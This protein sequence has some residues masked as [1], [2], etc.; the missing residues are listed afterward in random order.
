[1]LMAM[2][3]WSALTISQQVTGN[4]VVFSLKKFLENPAAL[5]F[6]LSLPAFLSLLTITV[7]NFVSD[8]IWTRYGRRKP[9]VLVGFA[10]MAVCLFLM[11]LM[12]NFWSLVGVYLL[13]GLFMDIDSPIEPLKQEIVPPQ[14][15]GTATGIMFWINQAAQLTFMFFVFGRFDDVTFMAG[16]P[17]TGEMGIYWCAALLS[18]SMLM[19]IALGIKE[20]KQRSRFTGEG[21][22]LKTFIGGLTDRELLPVYI[23]IFGAAVLHASTG[24]MGALLYTDQW[25]YTKQDM[26]TN[27]AIGG[28]LNLFLIALLTLLADRLNRLRAYQVLILIAIGLN[29]F[30]YCYVHFILPDRRP[31]LFEMVLFGEMMSVTG[32]LTGLVYTPLIYD[33]VVRN[34][35]GTY[36]AGAQL[37][38][39]LTNLVTVN[40]AGLFIVGYAALFQPPA[41]DMTRVA[42]RHPTTADEIR[43][44]LLKS[45]ELRTPEGKPVEAAD[46]HVAV[47]NRDGMVDKI[48][49][50][51]EIRV[52]SPRS[53]ELEAARK[54]VLDRLSPLTERTQTLNDRIELARREND[55]ATA[56]RLS[57]ELAKIAPERDR[58]RAE[59]ESIESAISERTAA[60]THS[61]ER[62]LAPLL[63]P[64]GSPLEPFVEL[65]VVVHSAPLPEG[66]A[67]REL[68]KLLDRAR[69]VF[70]ALIDVVPSSDG[71]SLEL[72]F[73]GDIPEGAPEAD[74]VR[75]FLNKQGSRLFPGGSAGV[76]ER[77]TSGF[78]VRVPTVEH[79]IPL[80]ESPVTAAVKHVR[81]LFGAAI[82]E[83]ERVMAAGRSLRSR[84]DWP[85]VGARADAGA[86]RSVSIVFVPATPT[87]PP[88]RE[89][90]TARIAK[91]LEA[92]KLTL[93]SPVL[94]SSYAKIKYDYMAGSLLT[95]LLGFVGFGITMVFYHLNKK[96]VIRKWGVEEAQATT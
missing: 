22:S 73:R 91:A 50:G 4:A 80:R 2:L 3:P 20:T 68:E 18:L 72:S 35:M 74:D 16:V 52:E 86:E 83:D 6:V 36:V 38:T 92:Q 67:N 34:K 42:L 51:M 70:P 26:G 29:I 66:T 1:M 46:L 19:L 49:K 5:T 40:G 84:P 90:M 62:I 37:V 14:Q 30:Y 11:P 64:A 75:A 89:E 24:P 55:T 27:I 88:D 25:G 79:P 77:R 58:F 15:R 47:W 94:A 8:R 56:Q 13:L 12:P 54:E 45:G 32:I 78:A 65:P 57:D 33:Y 48:G 96:G 87:S 93:V 59:L 7:T 60:V 61:I 71:K 85:H 82:H 53:D 17:I 81:R 95:I 76:K 28:V 21:L 31:S 23:L 9:F 69:G 43:E 39:R 41:G 44:V 63:Q 10:G